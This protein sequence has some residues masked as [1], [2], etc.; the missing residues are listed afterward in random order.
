MKEIKKY[1]FIPVFSVSVGLALY[2]L[3]MGLSGDHGWKINQNDCDL[4][5]STSLKSLKSLKNL[6]KGDQ[7]APTL[8]GKEKR[9]KV[10]EDEIL[11]ITKKKTI[12]E[13][14]LP[15]ALM[16]NPESMDKKLPSG[17]WYSAIRTRDD[18]AIKKPV[19]GQ[20]VIV[21]YTGW[22]EQDNEK[23]IF[24]SSEKRGVPFRFTVGVGQVIKGWDEGILL[25]RKGEKF[26][27]II[28]PHLAYGDRGAGNVIPPAATLHFD[29]DL[30][31]I[32]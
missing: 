30:I 8:V 16:I 5:L 12:D 27:F 26:N 13:E 21:H 9:D 3:R 17:L 24:D 22:I 6:N 29:V 7:G 14:M 4:S 18:E 11:E 23:R 31:D 19:K 10:L 28:P 1:W 2:Y 25:M 32:I 15:G 20:T